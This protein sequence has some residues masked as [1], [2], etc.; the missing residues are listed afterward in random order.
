MPHLK[1]KTDNTSTAPVV[2]T[3]PK[4]MDDEVTAEEQDAM[5]DWVEMQ[6]ALVEA[7]EAELEARAEE[8]KQETKS[9]VRE[10]T[11]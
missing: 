6:A 4:L 8:V 3:A 2:S 1:N 9:A 5:D 7:E 11:N 10:Q